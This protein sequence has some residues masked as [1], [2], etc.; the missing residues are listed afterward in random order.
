MRISVFEQTLQ[1]EKAILTRNKTL[2]GNN[3]NNLLNSWSEHRTDKKTLQP[4][5]DFLIAV[6]NA[7]SHNQYPMSTNTVMEDIEK[8]NIRTSRLAD[9]DGLGIASQLAKKTKDAAS[10]LQN[11]I[12]GG[13]N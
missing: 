11:I 7:F 1:L 4:D 3:F 6:R 9:K 8:F 2:C 12:N 5:I 10:R 13:T